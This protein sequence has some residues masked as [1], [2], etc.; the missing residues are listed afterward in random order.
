MVNFDPLAA[1]IY[2]RLGHPSKFERVSYLGSVTA[3]QSIIG[4]QPNFAAF[5][6][7]HHLYPA[8]RPSR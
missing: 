5:N 7:G 2:P 4:R 8:G 3:R 6:R 1:E